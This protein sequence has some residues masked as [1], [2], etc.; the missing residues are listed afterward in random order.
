MI[1]NLA[2]ARRGMLLRRIGAVG[3]TLIELMVTIAVFAILIGIAVPS[4]NE[5]TLGSKLASLTNNLVSSAALARSEAIKRNGTVTLCLAESCPTSGSWEQ[6]WVVIDQ[7]GS[8][9]HRQNAAPAGFHITETNALRK[10]DFKPSG[11]GATQAS[12]TI[13]RTGGSQERVLEISAAGRTSVRKT[14]SG[15]CP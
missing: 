3:F 12:F 11:V 13:C 7:T 5:A 1:N 2:I 9:I 15:T 6:G 14:N 10:I 4:L 8:A